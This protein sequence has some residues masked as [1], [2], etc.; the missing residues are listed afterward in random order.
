MIYNTPLQI[1]TNDDFNQYCLILSVYVTTLAVQ[2]SKFS[3]FHVSTGNALT[4]SQRILCIQL[5][6]R[7]V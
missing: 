4:Q 7:L 5:F 1:L 6:V 2:L 3:V